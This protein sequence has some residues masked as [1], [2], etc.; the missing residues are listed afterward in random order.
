MFELA[1]IFG[2]F[3]NIVFG[4]LLGLAIAIG[5]IAIETPSM[6]SVILGF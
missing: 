5:Q 4:G 1:D 2:V 6:I 3:I